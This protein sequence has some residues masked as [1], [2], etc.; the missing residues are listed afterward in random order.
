MII[1]LAK[2][3]D[4]DAFAELVKRR[5]SIVKQL[6]RRL[7]SNS[8]LAEDLCQQAFL[9]AYLKISSLRDSDAFGGWLKQL[10]INTWLQHCRKRDLLRATDEPEDL[11]SND[12]QPAVAMDLDTAL[13]ALK[14][15]ERLCVVLSYQEGMSHQEIAN[16]TGLALGTVK[17]HITRGTA[18][19]QASLSAYRTNRKGEPES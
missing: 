14:T 7:C 16:S 8:V 13:L 17:S 4:K 2:E 15:S 6:M 9:Q 10:T 11:L 5:Q 1:T 19:L 3:G 18:R 12:E